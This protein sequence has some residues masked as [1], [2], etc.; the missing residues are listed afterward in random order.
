MQAMG[1]RID[2]VDCRFSPALTPKINEHKFSREV[3]WWVSC[4]SI[5][6]NDKVDGIDSVNIVLVYSSRLDVIQIDVLG[7]LYQDVFFFS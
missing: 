5:D 2:H 7:E 6:P 4:S 3:L 1:E